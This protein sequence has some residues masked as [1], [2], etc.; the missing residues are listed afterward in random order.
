MLQ[1]DPELVTSIIRQG[2]GF[3]R[4]WTS[5]KSCPPLTETT[6]RQTRCFKAVLSS[7][8]VLCVPLSFL[9]VYLPL[10]AFPEL[11]SRICEPFCNQKFKHKMSVSEFN[12]NKGRTAGRVEITFINCHITDWIY[13]PQCSRTAGTGIFDGFWL[14]LFVFSGLAR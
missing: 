6:R 3:R 10:T 2:G 11:M 14:L 5:H 9:Q 13:L 4:C 8:S 1:L 12:C 7:L